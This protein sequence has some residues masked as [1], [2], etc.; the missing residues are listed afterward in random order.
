MKKTI[1][2]LALLSSV[3]AIGQLR[4]VAPVYTTA[5]QT[6][7]NKLIDADANTITNISDPAIKS[8]AGIDVSKMADGSVSNAEFQRLDGVNSNIQP[9]L[10]DKVSKFLLSSYI[11]VGNAINEAAPVTVSG[12]MTLSNT[13]NAQIASGAIVNA[14]I[15]NSAGISAA[16][17]IDGS[18][19]DQELGF[20]NS[21]TSD[22]Q[23][24]LN[25]R[26]TKGGDAGAF[27]IGTTNNNDLTIRLNN[28]DR[29]VFDGANGYLRRG[30]GTASFG[31]QFFGT[32]A[33]STVTFGDLFDVS[34]PYMM[35]RE[36]NG[37]DTDQGQFYSQ[38]GAG[39]FT[40]TLDN[41][42]ELWVDQT[43]RTVIGGET[44]VTGN[45][46]TV[47]GSSDISSNLNVQGNGT[48]GSHVKYKASSTPT[49]PAN[50]TECNVYF[51]SNKLV[52]QY[53][54]AGTTRY[55]YLDLNGTGVTWIHTTVAP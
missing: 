43:G 1:F 21:L 42:P 51:K 25:N 18:V 24:Q 36:R 27:S 31:L 38:K 45:A 37:T 50:G 15:N 6:L 41:T 14:D 32:G 2:L 9:Q 22:A 11:Y 48:F 23:T 52:I 3:Y 54:D 20:I 10:E 53:N 8:G 19:S 30:N 47:I 16:K 28:T 13:G 49:T 33:G 35:I 40:G 4:T 44:A 55:K 26:V 5:S 7:T 17:L 39:I 12:D 34:T 29:W 46:L